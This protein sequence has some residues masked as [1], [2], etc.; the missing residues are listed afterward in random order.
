MKTSYL[1]VDEYKRAPTGI[2][3]SDL[4]YFSG[5]TDINAQDAELAMVIARAS[6]WVDNYCQLPGG[7]AASTN[8]ETQSVYITRDGY[9]RIRPNNIP[10]L[11]LQELKWRVNP[12]MSWTTIDVTQVQVLDR[13]LEAM[14]WFP[15][16]DGPSLAIGGSYALP[17]STSYTSYVDPVS[18]ARLEDIK[19]TVQFT[20]TNGYPNPSLA[21]DCASGAQSITVDDVV[22]IDSGTNLTMYD[23][24]KTENITVTSVTGNTLL[25]NAPLIFSHSKGIGVSA[26]PA[27]VKAA[28]ILIVNYLLK[29]R[30]VN[31][32]TLEGAQNPQMQKYDDKADIELA[33][34]MLRQYRRVV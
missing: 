9:L 32:I 13:L 12:T 3:T 18:A 25:L 28:C 2:N 14:M 22:G 10:V 7:L 19:L 6:A 1:T 27:E 34:S 23:G 5:T 20:Y 31:S 33:K 8:T 24:A 4:D 29:E 21:V 17:M 26:I 11:S 30:G 16:G 15:L